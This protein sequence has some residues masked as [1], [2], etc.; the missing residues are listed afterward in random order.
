[1][2]NVLGFLGGAAAG[3]LA[4][5]Y[6]DPRLGRTRR[7]LVRDKTVSACTTATDYT[8]QQARRAGNSVRG[9]VN[10]VR[11]SSAPADDGQ[12][13]ERIRAKLGRVSRHPGAIH[14]DVED[15]RV[16][17]TG[18]VLSEEIDDVLSVVTSVKGVQDVEN[19]LSVHDEPGNI[20]ALQGEGKLARRNGRF[21]RPTLLALAPVAIAVVTAR[22]AGA[23]QRLNWRR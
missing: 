18:H 23:M 20:P 8:R 3:A 1:M 11:P 2:R 19:L 6:L 12:L 10:T 7:A 22:R 15:G 17:L 9:L 21:L 14:L 13:R 4:M 5:Y 16:R